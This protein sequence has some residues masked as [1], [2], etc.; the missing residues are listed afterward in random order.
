MTKILVGLICILASVASAQSFEVEVDS[1]VEASCL[2]CHG[3]ETETPLDMTKLGHDLSDRATFNAWEKIYHRVR[4]REM[5][6]RSEPRIKRAVLESTLATMK[7]SLTEA[8]IAARGAQRTA[9][10]RLTRLEYGYTIADLLY[11]DEAA[12]MALVKTL[13]AEGDSG[14]FD[15]VAA[16]QSMSPLHVRSYLNAADRA[17]D[18]ALRI[19]PRIK[20]QTFKKDYIRSGVLS[21]IANGKQLG[22][23]IIKKLDDAYVMFFDYGSTYTFYSRAEGFNVTVPGRYRVAFDAYPYQATSTVG[24]AVYKGRMGSV[25]ASLDELIGAFDLVDNAPR[26]VEL[27]TYLE[28]GDLVSPVP[29]DLIVRGNPDPDRNPNNGSDVSNYPGEGIALKSLTIEGPLIDSVGNV[30]PTS[31]TRELLK[32]VGFTD[33][34][35]VRLSKEPYEHILEIVESFAVRAFRRPLEDG[36]LEGYA[37]L[38]KPLLD[39]GRSFVD[40]VRVPLRAILSAPAFLYQSG[41][42]EVLDDFALATRLSYFL[43]RSMPDEKL[44]D[45]A[46]NGQLTDEAVL[47]E[48]VERLLAHPKS[49]RFVDDFA[50]QTFRL[51]ELQATAPDAGLYPE[52]NDRLGEAMKAETELFLAALIADNRSAGELIDSDFTFVNRGL[53]KHYRF[54]AVEGQEM[55]RVS[56]P[57][58]SPRGG[59]LTQA[60]IHKITANGTNTSPI[61]R[62]NFVLD[63]LL[64][65]PAPPPP[66]SVEALEPDTRGTTTIRE[67]LDAHRNEPVCASCHMNID[68]P[69]FAMESFDPIGRY[70]EK[71][72][73]GG[74]MVKYGDFMAPGPYTV[75]AN[76]DPSGVTPKGFPFKGINDYKK[77]LMDEEVEQVARNLVSKF[78]VFSTGAEIEFADRDAVEAIVARGEGNNY[79]L[80]DMIHLVVQSDLF[81]RQ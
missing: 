75:G 58:D 11:L 7:A 72:R 52:Y 68:P 42:S 61:P 53:A 59:L 45:L 32:G 70:R 36:E 46:G 8:N 79:A 2:K 5:P 20:T 63:N 56:I 17:L 78:L 35:E 51:Y 49:K 39:E 14:G 12:A 18:D 26:T 9:L 47:A 28:P 55:R 50:G 1:F 69:G 13:P 81:R 44:F 73:V 29:F 66:A 62:G 37:S 71:Y 30:W 23:G 22:F 76:V 48:Q 16:H 31:G 21:L 65:T 64:G 27:T 74:G 40:A 77:L 38:A 4:N 19:G 43:W 10:R 34:G 25:T 60:S 67:Q 24:L 41:N 80:K 57:E 33:T 15:T 6:P 54:P 3:A